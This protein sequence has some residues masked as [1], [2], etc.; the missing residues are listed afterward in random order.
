MYRKRNT[1]VKEYILFSLRI[2]ATTIKIKAETTTKITETLAVIKYT[3][4]Q[5]LTVN[6]K[7][8]AISARKRI[9]V[10][11]DIQKRNTIRLKRN[12]KATS[13]IK[14]KDGLITALKNALSR[15]LL[16]AKETIV[17]T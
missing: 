2:A 3:D 9:A 1:L 13:V 10:Y 4:N 6:L 15:I 8:I 7:D 12:I 11:R 16:T 17:R 5:I 14:L